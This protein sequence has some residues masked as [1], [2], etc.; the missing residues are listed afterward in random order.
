MA[1]FSWEDRSFSIIRCA[2]AAIAVGCLSPAFAQ[3]RTW[4]SDISTRGVVAFDCTD[5]GDDIGMTVTCEQKGLPIIIEVNHASVEAGRAGSVVPVSFQIG[6]ERFSLQARTVF[7]GQIGFVPRVTVAANSRLIAA[8]QAARTDAIVQFGRSTARIAMNG[9]GASIAA[10]A[11]HCMGSGA[12]D[13]A[14]VTSPAD[15]GVVQPSPQGNASAALRGRDTTEVTFTNALSSDVNYYIVDPATNTP[16]Y[17]MTLRPGIKIVQAAR[18]GMRFVFGIEDRAI[19]EFVATNGAQSHIIALPASPEAASPPLLNAQVAVKIRNGLAGVVEYHALDG[20]GQAQFLYALRPGEE[21]EQPALPGIR[22]IFRVGGLSI[23]QYET[24]AEASQ[25]FVVGNEQQASEQQPQALPSQTGQSPQPAG[26]VSPLQP[27]NS[28]FDIVDEEG[29]TWT[30]GWRGSTVFATFGIPE[31][32]ATS[33]SVSCAPNRHVG[34]EFFSAPI[35]RAGRSTPLDLRSTVG[36]Y[37][38]RASANA[39]GRPS[40]QFTVL[41]FGLLSLLKSADVIEISSGGQSAGRFYGLRSSAAGRQFM[42][43][44]PQIGAP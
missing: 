27:V 41:D 31:T 7:Y 18:E 14:S 15:T 22:L 35:A 37:S 39:Q 9:A 8:L 17:V 20:G 28:E 3:E 12:S 34:L 16:V 42:L 24:T 36:A 40:G 4:S 44:C 19:G 38:F 30:Y 10:V 32:D 29:A 13:D 23:A 6:Q 33:I 2:G 26:A 11:A 25:S 21:V 43:N 5:C 1:S